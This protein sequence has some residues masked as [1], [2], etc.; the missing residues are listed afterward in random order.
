MSLDISALI[1]IGAM[2]V[3]IGSIYGLVRS[4]LQKL[5]DKQAEQRDTNKA[6]FNKHDLLD[7]RIND[8]IEH[9]HMR[10]K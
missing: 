6:L 8:H 7:R 10:V 5:H 9:H 3:G 2:L 1:N 4:D